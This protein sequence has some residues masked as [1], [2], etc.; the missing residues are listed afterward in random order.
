MPVRE[1]ST[2]ISLD[3]EKAFKQALSDASRNLSEMD[4]D[5]KAVSAEFEATGNS[6][7]YMTE[8]SRLLKSEIEQQERIVDSLVNAVRESANMYGDASSKTDNYRIQLSSATARLTR[9]KMELADT[10]R[11][12]EEFGRDS[13]RVGRQIERGIGDAAEEAGE[14]L[15]DMIKKIQSDIGN[16]RA[17]ATF[18]VV[19]QV[20]TFVTGSIGKMVDFVNEY[21]DQRQKRA[22]TLAGIQSEMALTEAEIDN[23][24]LQIMGVTDDRAGAYETLQLLAQSSVGKE[25][26]GKALELFLGANLRFGQEAKPEDLAESFQASVTGGVLTGKLQELFEKRLN[27]NIDSINAALKDETRESRA[28]FLLNTMGAHGLA[29]DYQSYKAGNPDLVKELA[30]NA[31]LDRAK[32]RLAES[33]S[34]ITTAVT[35]K[36][37]EVVDVFASGMSDIQ[38]LL[39]GEEQFSPEGFWNGFMKG[40]GRWGIQLPAGA[41]AEEAGAEDGAAYAGAAETAAKEKMPTMADIFGAYSEGGAE[42]VHSMLDAAQVSD[43]EKAT[44]IES[45]RMLGLDMGTGFDTTLTE[46]MKNA[47]EN[48]ATSGANIGTAIENGLKQTFPKA[49]ATATNFTNMLDAVVSR[50][51]SLASAIPVYGSSGGSSSMNF[52]GNVSGS[53]STSVNLNG[54]QI[55]AAIT[56]YVS[57]MQGQAVDRK[58][59]LG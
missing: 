12:A 30:A 11:A 50:A 22:V 1:I 20:A 28:L 47:A 38:K 40:L 17:S 39:S 55:A 23:Y 25:Y 48:A 59:R 44:I 26:F 27:E 13:M 24:L 35:E 4:S 5:L 2:R 53:V 8:R 19:S 45:M 36:S 6:Q 51:N 7:R 56:P 14:S 58:S 54:R 57:T 34:P 29:A 16:I 15:G 43:E 46:E 41:S 32:E 37:A 21:R 18:S 52:T 31:K 9:M 42:A 49:I 10:D 33:V 3:G